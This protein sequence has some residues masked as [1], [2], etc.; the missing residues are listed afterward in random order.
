GSLDSSDDETSHGPVGDRGEPDGCWV[1]VDEDWQPPSE[2]EQPDDTTPVAPLSPQRYTPF[3]RLLDNADGAYHAPQEVT[4]DYTSLCSIQRVQHVEALR[5]GN[6]LYIGRDGR[7]TF[8]QRSV[9]EKRP[10]QQLPPQPAAVLDQALASGQINLLP[11]DNPKGYRWQDRQGNWIE[12][13]TQGQIVGYGDPNQNRIWLVR[14]EG[15]LV[16]GVVDGAGRV[17][18]TLHYQDELLVEVRDAPIAGRSGDLPVRSVKYRY[19]TARRLTEVIDARGHSS[20]YQYDRRNRLIRL[21]D[22]AGH[23][24][25]LAYSDF[26]VSRHTAADGGVTDYD[27]DFD[28]RTAR[29]HTKVTGPV[30]AAGRRVDDYTHYRSG[31][32]RDHLVNGQLQQSER[33]DSATRSRTYTNARGFSTRIT[34]N[35]FDQITAIAYPDGSKLQ[36]R[37]SALHLGLMEAIDEA[38]IKTEYQ[39]DQRG[40]LLRQIDAA[41]TADQRITDYTRNPLGQI[42]QVTRTGRTE[43]NGTVTPDATWQLAY[44]AQGQ[45]SQTIDPEGGVREYVY[46]RAGQLIRSTD[47][48]GQITTY[49]HDA[50]GHLLS[51]TDPLGRVT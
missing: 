17:L 19:D 16:R 40:N 22:P 45:L 37:Y 18:Y 33:S 43:A 26:S 8:N 20:H 39:R 34:R 13:N 42:T 28:D 12:Y 32:L 14:D 41:G 29:F 21:T 25:Q 31:R 23:S 35:E 2:P 1:W 44:D 6:E 5:R 46:N 36:R 9:L 4:L 10:V 15:S 27:Y 7:Y 51:V 24:E 47:P 30:T 50:A 49:Q 48:L 3:N 38:G 11:E